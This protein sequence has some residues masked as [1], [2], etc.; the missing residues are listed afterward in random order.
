M[1]KLLSLLLSVALVFG[2]AACSSS[3][4]GTSTDEPTTTEDTASEVTRVAILLPHIGDQSY[5]DVTANA[6]NVLKERLGDAIEVNVIEMGDD[7]ADWEPANMQAAEEGYDI[8]VS[9]NWQYEAAMLA[10]AAQYPDIKYLNFDYSDAAAN[11]LDNVYGITYASNQIGYFAGLVAA[12]KSQSGIIGG[13]VGQNNAGMNQ[14]MAGYIQGASDV[15]PDIQVIITYVGSYTD[16]AT[17]KE[18]A[19]GMINEGADVIWGCAGGSGNGVFEA[20]SENPGVWAIGVDTDQW[21][22]MS[23][24]PELQAT[25]LTSAEKRCDVAIADA[26]EKIINGTA[27]FGTQEVLGYAENAVGLSENDYYKANMTEDELAIVNSFAEKVASGE[28]V[29][30]DELTEPGVFEQYYNQYGKK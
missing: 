28:T 20:V 5:M 14:F 6:A 3:N 24:K 11:S 1:K 16:P 4:S 22:S 10:V 18:Q 29:V 23:A 2:L 15:N 7:E 12:V 19:Q 30:V 9:G 27:P 26:V 8:I 13:V 17:A 21:V 25:I